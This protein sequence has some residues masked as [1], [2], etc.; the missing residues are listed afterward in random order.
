MEEIS[1]SPRTVRLISD[2][3]IDQEWL[4][5]LSEVESRSAIVEANTPESM[6]AIEDVKPLLVNLKD[7]VG[8]LTRGYIIFH[9]FINFERRSNEFET[10]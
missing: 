3:P 6:K 2:G 10:T 7:K 4:K 8:Q 5:V 1:I 9:S